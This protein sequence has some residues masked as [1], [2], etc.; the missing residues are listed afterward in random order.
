MVTSSTRTAPWTSTPPR[1]A[2][3]WT[4]TPRPGGARHHRGVL[5]MTD[6]ENLWRRRSRTP[7]AAGCRFWRARVEPTP[8]TPA[9]LPQA[10]KIGMDGLLWSPRTTT[11]PP[12]P[13]VEAHSALPPWTPWTRPS[14]CTT[15]QAAPGSRS[16]PG[17]CSPRTQHRGR[18]GRQGGLRRRVPGHGGDWTSCLDSATTRLYPAVDGHRRRRLVG[19]NHARGHRALPPHDRRRAGLGPRCPQAQRG[20]CCPSCAPP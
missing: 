4:T 10:E 7:W 6:E 13:G 18:Q 11:S 3:S 14:R 1:P 15:S 9:P 19:V 2:S 5:T 17:H 16:S 8:S 12:R 20:S